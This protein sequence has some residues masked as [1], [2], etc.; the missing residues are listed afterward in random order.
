MKKAHGFPIYGDVLGSI[1]ATH[2]GT[3]L[4]HHQ[5]Q[6]FRG[7]VK[8]QAASRISGVVLLKKSSPETSLPIMCQ[9]KL[10]PPPEYGICFMLWTIAIYEFFKMPEPF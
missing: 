9:G 10:R 8:G 3:K 2:P 4:V 5:L 7:I 1:A 6:G